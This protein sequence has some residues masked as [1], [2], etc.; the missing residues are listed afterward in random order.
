M[1]SCIENMSNK[2]AYMI[3]CHDNFEHLLKLI[4]ALD[5]IRNDIYIHVDRKTRNMPFEQINNAAQ[6]AKIFWMKRY[7]VNW[8][9]SSQV[10]I[11]MQLLKMATKEKHVYYHLISG[12]D[13]QIKSQEYIHSFFEINKGNEYIQFDSE[14]RN[15]YDR[16]RYYYLFQNII[17]RNKGKIPAL[18]FILQKNVLKI[19]QFFHMDRIKKLPYEVYKGTNWFSISHNLAVFLIQNQKKIKSLC[20]LTLCAD[21][22][23]LQTFAMMSPY[24]DNI[25]NNSL[26]YIDWKRGTPYTFTDMEFEELINTDKLFAR[27]FDDTASLEVVNR[28]LNHFSTT[29]LEDFES[30][31]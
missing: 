1:E 3:I 12:V 19:Q 25:V 22:V 13:F 24:K 18:A 27:K 23:F 26:R 2:H 28:L 10:Q 4:K 6:K 8:G 21:E 30:W 7:S 9:G 17:G 11:E 20:R 31:R 16:V 15:Y 5:D 29:K 14:D